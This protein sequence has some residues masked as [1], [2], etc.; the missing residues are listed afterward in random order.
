V[1][2]IFITVE[3]GE[4][5]VRTYRSL[6][7]KVLGHA[8]SMPA[9][10]KSV[11]SHTRI[12]VARFGRSAGFWTDPTTISTSPLGAGAAARATVG[13]AKDGYVVLLGVGG[14]SNVV[15]TA[16]H[17]LKDALAPLGR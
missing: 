12:H 16:E 2:F 3:R 14:H 7:R 10:T 8:T 13:A 4:T 6:R 1:R 5:A 11:L 17:A 9:H 15:T